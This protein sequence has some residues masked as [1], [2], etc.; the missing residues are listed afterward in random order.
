MLLDPLLLY[1]VEITNSY[2]LDCV[3][4]LKCRSSIHIGFDLAEGHSLS[5]VE[6]IIDKSIY[7]R[8]NKI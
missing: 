6:R 4:E 1:F 3:H 7:S 2:V 8:R 5:E